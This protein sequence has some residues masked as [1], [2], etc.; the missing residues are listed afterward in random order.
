MSD[1]P[2]ARSWPF[3]RGVEHRDVA[4]STNDLAREIVTRDAEPP[5]PMLVLADR[6]TRGRGR[7]ANRWWSDAGSLTFTVALDPAAHG[8]RP[9]QV[10]RS[11]LAAAVAT[12]AALEAG[13]W[14]PAGAAGIRW[15]ND[16]EIADRKLAGLL[17]E[18][19]ETPRGPRLLLGIGV[20]VSTDV[21]VAPP[22]VQVLATSLLRERTY[23]V[24]LAPPTVVLAPILAAL[25]KALSDLAR[26]SPALAA[27][28]RSLDRLRDRAVWVDLGDRV[29]RGVGAGIDGDGRLLLATETGVVSLAGGRVLR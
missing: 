20:N 8:L 3:V 22:D 2:P 28:W 12:I 17:A 19:V 10:P 13:G 15:P 5:L 1:R 6:Q 27:M 14:L 18:Q 25:E 16:I 4:D 7:G 23:P 21:E 29:V 24:P 26:E 11:A 9:E